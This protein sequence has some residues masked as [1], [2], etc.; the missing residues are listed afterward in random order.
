MR[1]NQIILLLLPLAHLAAFW[2]LIGWY[3]RRMGEPGDEA[4]GIL[5]L[6][7]ALVIA[8]QQRDRRLFNP[9]GV[10]LAAFQLP[11]LAV[12]VAATLL[13]AFTTAEIPP[14]VRAGIAMTALTSTI[15]VC[16]LGRRF[17]AGLWLLLLLSLPVMATVDFY[18]GYPL[19]VVVTRI[20]ALVLRCSGLAV[21]ASGAILEWNG[22]LVAVDVPCSGIRMLWS[23]GFIALALACALRM[24]LKRVVALGIMSAILIIAGNILRATALFYTGA[25]IISAPPWMHTG[26]GA[27]AFALT[28]GGIFGGTAWLQ[29]RS[30]RKI[31]AVADDKCAGKIRRLAGSVMLLV[32]ATA[33]LMAA[34]APVWARQPVRAVYDF[35]GWPVKVEGRAIRAIALSEDERKF[36][37]DFPGRIGRFTDGSR[38]IILRWVATPTRQL[39]PAEVCFKGWG[40][41]VEPQPLHRTIDGESW[42]SFLARRGRE[43]LAVRTC[44]RDADGKSWPDVSSWYWPSALGRSR[45]PWL[46]TTIAERNCHGTNTV[47]H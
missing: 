18:A 33:C 9:G 43:T 24:P 11:W 1:R 26:V 35:P 30:N 34:T 19:R 37:M 16:W 7:T 20:A 27:C 14:L 23:G 41:S 38:E 25:G 2:P 21:T 6:I 31:Q 13:Y 15:S 36:A 10:A 47:M 3:C 45:G 12:A 46:A 28:S 29:S 4:L 8:W 42:G 39:H 32:L 22:V 5:V 40:Y 17:H 44:I